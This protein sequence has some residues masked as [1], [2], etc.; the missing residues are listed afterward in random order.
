[1]HA[2]THARTHAP[3]SAH[4]NCSLF[5]KNWSTALFV[6]TIYILIPNCKSE[7]V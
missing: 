5:I 1:M 4:A 7:R 2:R 3:I 6:L